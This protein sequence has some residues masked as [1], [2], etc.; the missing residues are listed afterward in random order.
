MRFDIIGDVHGHALRLEVLLEKM[1]YH[2][3]PDG[4]R[5][6]K[7][8]AVFVGDL[9]DRGPHQLDTLRLVR[10]MVESGAA[11]AVMGN[12]EFNAIGFL[13]SVVDHKFV[14]AFLRQKRS[15]EARISSA[16]LVQR[17][18]AGSALCCSRKDVMSARRA[19][20]LR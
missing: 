13:A 15:I 18:G 19:A 8:T 17:K 10:D 12:H 2:K 7:R 14:G 3:R 9:V 16:D 1:G 20:T 6:P 5:H 4:W 11:R